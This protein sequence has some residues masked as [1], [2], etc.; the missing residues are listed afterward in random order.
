[1]IIRGRT[2]LHQAAYNGHEAVVR[3]LLEY[4]ADIDAKDKV[5][6]KDGAARG[7]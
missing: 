4:K 7:G 3:L 5:L 2:A 1:M 6:W